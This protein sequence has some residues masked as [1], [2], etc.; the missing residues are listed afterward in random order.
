MDAQ[1]FYQSIERHDRFAIQ[2]VR[3]R[4][5]DHGLDLILTR[6][7]SR[8]FKDFPERSQKEVDLLVR[9]D[10]LP[11]FLKAREDID[12]YLLGKDVPPFTFYFPEKNANSLLTSHPTDEAYFSLFAPFVYRGITFNFRF[13]RTDD[14]QRNPF[15]VD[16]LIN[17]DVRTYLE[18]LASS[19]N[20]KD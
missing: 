14:P 6:Y 1:E 20:K 12:A 9:G 19:K 8:I 5:R 15:S 18:H 17:P 13:S 4:C 11:E 16:I 3:D 2:D 10:C 7:S